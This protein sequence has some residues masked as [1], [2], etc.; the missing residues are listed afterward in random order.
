MALPISAIARRTPTQR[1]EAHRYRVETCE[2]AANSATKLFRKSSFQQLF[3]LTI[4][5]LGFICRH[6]PLVHDPMGRMTFLSSG[7]R[8]ASNWPKNGLRSNRIA[9]KFLGEHVI[10]FLR[11]HCQHD[12]S[13]SDGY[14]PAGVFK[15]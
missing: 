15:Q 7:L 6:P 12:Q 8:E 4:A 14:G 1:P 13:K 9:P 10:A 5:Q 3:I 11:A 2:M